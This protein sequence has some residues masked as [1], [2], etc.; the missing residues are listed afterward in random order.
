MRRCVKLPAHDCPQNFPDSNQLTWFPLFATWL[1]L[2]LTL[3]SCLGE[4]ILK[5]SFQ[6]QR[7]RHS[8]VKAPLAQT[9]ASSVCRCVCWPRS[10]PRI[11][12]LP[13]QL[14]AFQHVHLCSECGR[15]SVNICTQ[16]KDWNWGPFILLPLLNTYVPFCIP[17]KI[18]AIR[19][20][21]KLRAAKQE[22]ILKA[23][24]SSSYCGTVSEQFHCSCSGG[25]GGIGLIP[26]PVQWVN[27]P[28]LPQ[29]WCRLQLWLQWIQS[30]DQELPYAAGQ[31]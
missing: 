25:W 3:F 28:V 21:R 7:A 10:A 19:G 11:T 18:H 17:Q 29:L 15:C 12:P 5:P 16:N 13:K 6:I 23:H 14:W 24:C 30:L 9:S 22:I 27:D 2:N 4:A 20:K 8:T 31:P 26:G 1:D